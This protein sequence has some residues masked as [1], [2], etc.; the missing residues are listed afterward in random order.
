MHS[1]SVAFV[2]LIQLIPPNRFAFNK[3]S[4]LP[5]YSPF[6]RG[7]FLLILVLVSV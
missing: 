6:M 1:N 3:E 2:I 5:L 4:S 7:M